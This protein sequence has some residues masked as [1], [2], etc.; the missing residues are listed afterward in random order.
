MGVLTD[1]RKPIYPMETGVSQSKEAII[2][3]QIIQ[4]YI[5]KINETALDAVVGMQLTYC[6]N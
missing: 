5:K 3:S 4:A 1:K 2:S 6:L